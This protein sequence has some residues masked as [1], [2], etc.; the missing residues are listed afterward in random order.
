[1][2]SQTKQGLVWGGLLILFGVMSLLE[3]FT[4]LSAWV[5]VAVLTAAGLGIYGFYAMDRTE[6]WMLFISYGLLVI[7]LMV[8]LI[9]L[10]LLRDEAIATYVLSAIALPFLLAYLRDRRLWGLLIPAY[11]LLAVGFMVGLIG[12]GVLD[13]WLIPAYVMIAISI[14]FFTVY[15][16]NNQ[17]WWALIP[18]GITALIGLSFMIADPSVRY[19]AP[20]ILILVGGWLVIRQFVKRDDGTGEITGDGDR[21]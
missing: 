21:T 18:G 6:K 11:I 16:R 7:P 15:L 12:L 19:V 20:V 5:W 8:A 17:H 3:T 4:D 9:E 14:P 2:N 13:D 10:D 1:M